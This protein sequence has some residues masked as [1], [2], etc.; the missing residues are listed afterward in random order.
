MPMNIT[1]TVSLCL[2]FLITISVCSC[3]S[4]RK[5]QT[6]NENIEIFI[7][8]TITEMENE[9]MG[10]QIVNTKVYFGTDSINQTTLHELT[11]IPRLFFY[12]SNNTCPP[13][14]DQSVEIIKE[15]FNDY[16]SNEK[17]IFISP[18]YPLRYSN[19]CYG[20]KLLKLK[21]ENLGLPIEDG[22]QP[23][24]FIIINMDMKV[25]SIHVVNKMDFERTREYLVR[26]SEIL[27]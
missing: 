27:I 13:C 1:K 7:H 24:F 15:I 9:N 21:N 18:D 16:E 10:K 3:N 12:F 23:P 26:I 5:K 2:S 22:F 17:I 19:N 25:E 8:N 14:I 11:N 4:G 6:E 20:K